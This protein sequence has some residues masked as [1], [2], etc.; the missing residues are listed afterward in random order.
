M[1]ATLTRTESVQRVFA[2]YELGED[3]SYGHVKTRKTRSRSWSCA[4]IR[5]RPAPPAC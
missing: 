2:A 3:K 4:A 5:Y 1:R